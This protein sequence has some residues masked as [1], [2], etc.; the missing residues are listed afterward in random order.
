[1]GSEPACLHGQCSVVDGLVDLPQISEAF[2][3]PCR[4]VCIHVMIIPCKFVIEDV[5][6]AGKET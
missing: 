3:S 5:K 2:Q 1:M 6:R 4:T